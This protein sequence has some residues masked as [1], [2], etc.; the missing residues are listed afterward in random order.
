[1][2]LTADNYFSFEN[3]MEY[4]GS[5][6]YKD[7]LQCESMALAKI[8]G[9]YAEEKTVSL[10]VGSYVDA[11][12]EGS[13]DK[14]IAENPDIVSSQG[15]TKGQLKSNYIQANYIIDRLNKDE[16][17]QKH[18]SGEKQVIKTGFIAGVPFK[19][20]ID[21]YHPH[22]EIVDL[23]I[24]KDFKSMWKDGLKLNF[25]EYWGYDIQGAI[26]QEIERQNSGESLPFILAAATKEKEPDIILLSV[27]NVRLEYCLGQVKQ[28]APRF[29]AIKKGLIKPTRCEC[30]DWCKSTK[31]LTAIYDYTIL[32]KEQI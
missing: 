22:K 11:Y 3:Q 23:K 27:S 19:I 16:M 10:L 8:K 9:E 17:F 28:N 1:M 15:K 29:D 20:K 32:D 24:I 30:C 21:S 4:M 7:F 5:S 14:F 2:E 6:Q 31:V 25:V 13:L 26:Y 12:Y 18:M